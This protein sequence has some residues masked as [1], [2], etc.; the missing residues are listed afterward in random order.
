M[1]RNNQEI[2]SDLSHQTIYDVLKFARDKIP[3]T[4]R[5]PP[6]I[7]REN[8]K[9]FSEDL[10]LKIAQAIYLMADILEKSQSCW[11][12]ATYL[13]ANS[14]SDYIDQCLR[15]LGH[16]SLFIPILRQDSD[17]ILFKLCV[18]FYCVLKGF[19]DHKTQTASSLLS[20]LRMRFGEAYEKKLIEDSPLQLKTDLIG[21]LKARDNTSQ[22]ELLEYIEG[23]GL[24]AL[25]IEWSYDLGKTA[26]EGIAT[27]LGKV[28]NKIEEKRSPILPLIRIVWK[29]KNK[30][31]NQAGH[32]L[33]SV[34]SEA[35]FPADFP[36][37]KPTLVQFHN[38]K[39]ELSVRF[40]QY[41]WPNVFCLLLPSVSDDSDDSAAFQLLLARIHALEADS[42]D[43][44]FGFVYDLN[45]KSWWFFD[46][47]KDILQ[48]ISLDISQS[49]TLRE[50]LRGVETT[51]KSVFRCLSNNNLN[52]IWKTQ[53]N[54]SLLKT[55]RRQVC[56]DLLDRASFQKLRFP[57]KRSD[58]IT[59]CYSADNWSNGLYPA[60]MYAYKKIER[61]HT[62][63]SE[64]MAV[65]SK[66]IDKHRAYLDRLKEKKKTYA[67]DQDE[68]AANVDN[69]LAIAGVGTDTI[70]SKFLS[71]WSI[72]DEIFHPEKALDSSDE[73]TSDI[74]QLEADIERLELQQFELRLEQFS[75]EYLPDLTQH[76]EEINQLLTARVDRAVLKWKNFSPLP[77]NGI[78]NDRVTIQQTRKIFHTKRMTYETIFK[79]LQREVEPLG[80][81]QFVSDEMSRAGAR[82]ALVA[83][84]NPLIVSRSSLISTKNRLA[85][86]IREIEAQFWDVHAQFMELDFIWVNLDLAETSLSDHFLLIASQTK[87][88]Y[89]QV[90]SFS[91]LLSTSKYLPYFALLASV[92]AMVIALGILLNYPLF[93]TIFVI[94]SLLVYTPMMALVGVS[95]GGIVALGSASVIAP[96]FFRSGGD[97][98]GQSEPNLLS[99]EMSGLPAT[100][101]AGEGRF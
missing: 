18:L 17:P 46:Q 7:P 29:M 92:A 74:Q 24:K 5:E 76:L 85:L 35:D 93:L 39:K 6:F 2:K 77:F 50:V 67:A 22:A 25:R 9:D 73:L 54:Q 62:S 16:P 44:K 11:V 64:K 4:F 21:Y 32:Y 57:D 95:L 38:A 82:S 10:M 78:K 99:S 14:R 30:V 75:M 96:R 70:V 94:P 53:A 61:K 40:V 43:F 41:R 71:A 89:N 19:G 79:S 97:E 8:P 3:S 65:L 86:R 100:I 47:T 83:T 36:M 1:S 28:Q 49:N 23:L 48:K 33:L 63:L 15:I 80:V 87:A 60:I 52:D 37:D 72:V 26:V 34:E 81:Y 101:G 58:Y 56:F 88:F 27:Q 45:K 59:L 84:D 90:V 51:K 91:L 68:Q 13:A 12:L 42:L 31:L 20:L 55:I 66:K 69:G 98:D